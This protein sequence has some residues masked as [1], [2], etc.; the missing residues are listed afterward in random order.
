M[1]D[2]VGESFLFESYCVVL[3][4]CLLIRVLIVHTGVPQGSKMSPTLFSFYPA[5]IHGR[6][7]Q[8]SESAMRTI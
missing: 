4:F 8:P 5:D 6:Q 1:F 3:V 2:G 7:N